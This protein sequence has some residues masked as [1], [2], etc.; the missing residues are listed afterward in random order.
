MNESVTIN[1]FAMK[2]TC[3]VFLSMRTIQKISESLFLSECSEKIFFYSAI[4]HSP[5]LYST[6]VGENITEFE[7]VIL[8]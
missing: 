7:F 1:F 6:N 4:Q 8:L 3:T 2:S 5:Q